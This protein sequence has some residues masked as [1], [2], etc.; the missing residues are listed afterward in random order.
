MMTE[1]QKPRFVAALAEL[2]LL[3][4]PKKFTPEEYLAWWNQLRSEWTLTEFQAA[5]KTLADE[6][7]WFP[8]VYHFA[9]LRRRAAE[10]SAADAWTRVLACVRNGDYRRGITVGG[11]ADRVVATLGG[12][13]ALGMSNTADTHFREKRFAE[14]WAEIGEVVEARKALPSASGPMRI[15]RPAAGSSVLGRLREGDGS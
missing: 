13:A 6:L 12:Y 2:A 5:C 15:G 4:P 7:E 9:Q 10:E 11:R 14:L 8:T 1:T 3:K